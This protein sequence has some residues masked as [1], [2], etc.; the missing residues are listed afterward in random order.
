MD[1]EAQRNAQYVLGHSTQEL[2]RLGAQARLY[3]PF[4]FQFL[5]DAGLETGMRVLDVGCGKGDMSFIVTR[6]VGPRGFGRDS[7]PGP[8]KSG[9]N[10][11]AAHHRLKGQQHQGG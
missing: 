6:L 7:L 8:P 5:R 9:R 4:T 11:G 1:G 10:P 3:D 2:A